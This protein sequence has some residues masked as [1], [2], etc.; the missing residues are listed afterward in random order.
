MKITIIIL[1]IFLLSGCGTLICEE[2]E[3]CSEYSVSIKNSFPED[4]YSD[5]KCNEAGYCSGIL[6]TGTTSLSQ[7]ECIATKTRMICR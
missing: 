4:C 3:Y 1:L 7:G 5:F 6:T 2:E